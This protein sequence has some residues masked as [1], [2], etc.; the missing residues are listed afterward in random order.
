MLGVI[1]RSGAGKSTMLRLVNRLCEADAGEIAW[2]G[3]C[4]RRLRGAKLRDWRR[5]CAMIFQQFNLVPR[6]DVITNVLVGSL[7]GRPLLPSLFKS[8]PEEL[9]A[10]AV[11]ELD[12]FGLADT[13]LKRAE[14]LSGGQQQR[15]AIARAMLQNP[16]IL[17]ADEP[18]ASLDPVNA[19][20]VMRALQQVNRERG[21]T[22]IVNLHA[23]EAAR[24]FCD[25]VIGMA[26]GRIVFDGTAQELTPAAV[27]HV[28]G[29]GASNG[30]EALRVVEPAA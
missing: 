22:V 11:L 28:Y 30:A 29:E 10:A 6:L 3:A 2:Q 1:G 16:D 26:A 14:H 19:Q 20:I 18:I 25:R 24:S 9:R 15:V 17:L 13:A 21:I 27:A 4:V 12:R 7:P 8:F 5:R 23:L